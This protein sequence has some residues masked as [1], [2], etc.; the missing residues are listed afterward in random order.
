MK[1]N[2]LL[3]AQQQTKMV[4]VM[5]FFIG[6]LMVFNIKNINAIDWDNVKSYNSNNQEVTIKNLFGLGNEIATI[7]HLTPHE[8]FVM[9]GKDRLV[10]ISFPNPNKFF[11][12]TS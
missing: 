4:W 8:N 9:P 1:K 11:I 10:A 3:E 12:V 7:T 6:F 5:I 2:S